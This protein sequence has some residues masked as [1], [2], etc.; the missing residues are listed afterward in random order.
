MKK[1]KKI[2]FPFFV[3]FASL[4]LLNGCK[5]DED[6][7]GKYVENPDWIAPIENN[8][9]YQ[10]TYVGQVA[11]QG[12]INDNTQTMVA[13]FCGSECRGL[14]NLKYEQDLGLYVFYLSIYSNE[15]EGETITIKAHN[16]N[17]KRMYLNCKTLTFVNDSSE[18]NINT[19]LQCDK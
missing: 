4:V 14:A 19:I 9:E 16:K 7:K 11:F 8:Y 15:L 10:M 5:K 3:I 18:G 13:A 1:N 12:K 6:K 17:T 2:I